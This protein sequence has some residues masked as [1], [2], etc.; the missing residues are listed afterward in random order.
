MRDRSCS[1]STSRTYCWRISRKASGPLASTSSAGSEGRGGGGTCCV[2][3]WAVGVCAAGSLD[4]LLSSSP[5]LTSSVARSS[6]SLA[7]FTLAGSSLEA[8]TTA[9]NKSFPTLQNPI[10]MYLLHKSVKERLQALNRGWRAASALVRYV[11][12]TS[13][14]SICTACINEFFLASSA[15]ISCKDELVI[16]LQLRAIAAV[17]VCAWWKFSLQ[18]ARK[19]DNT[20]G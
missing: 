17:C 12:V 7:S 9:E 13:S 19:V 15:V 1:T 5:L 14:V 3:D 2:V 20:P 4:P 8:M 6:H 10:A 11:V 16:L 18:V